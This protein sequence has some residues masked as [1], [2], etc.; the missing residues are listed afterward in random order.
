MNTLFTTA[1]P[2]P[3]WPHLGFTSQ[4]PGSGVTCSFL[5]TASGNWKSRP[6]DNFFSQAPLLL[7]TRARKNPPK[8][9]CGSFPV[10]RSARSQFRSCGSLNL[11]RRGLRA[12]R[13]R[14]L[15]FGAAFSSLQIGLTAFAFLS[16]VIL[17]AHIRSLLQRAKSF[18]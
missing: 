3:P 9:V 5:F 2:P 17:F 15:G 8:R 1:K 13:R 18:V 14:R 11:G 16:F 10:S 6:V 4:N 7:R 12:N